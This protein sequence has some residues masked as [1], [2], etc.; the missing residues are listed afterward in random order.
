MLLPIVRFSGAYLIN[1]AFALLGVRN[2]CVKSFAMQYKRTK[3]LYALEI[4]YSTFSLLKA[5]LKK[6]LKLS[7]G[8]AECVALCP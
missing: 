3:L 7:T 2:V 4:L 6:T 5:L 8:G 1:S